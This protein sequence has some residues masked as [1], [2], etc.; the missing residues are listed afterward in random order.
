MSF[1]TL[2][3]EFEVK[4]PELWLVNCDEEA[5]KKE[6][7][8]SAKLFIKKQYRLLHSHFAV[9]NGTTDSETESDSESDTDE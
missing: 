5:L 2:K 4:V 8:C 1:K 7:E 9:S 3:F 6:V